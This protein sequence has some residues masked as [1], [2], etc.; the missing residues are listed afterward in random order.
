MRKKIVL[1]PASLPDL[2]NINLNIQY[3][4]SCLG[5]F[6][7]RDKDSSCFRLFVELVKI[8]KKKS[9]ISS[10]ELAFKLGLSRGTVVH[11][12]NKLIAAGIVTRADNRYFL[13]KPTMFQVVEHI[14]KEVN[15]LMKNLKKV[16]KKL[17]EQIGME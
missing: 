17:D 7:L 8:A 1:Y 10:D 12:L 15:T 9:V 5:L 2:S 14:E 11:H 6:G 3:L 16:A 13:V 4:G